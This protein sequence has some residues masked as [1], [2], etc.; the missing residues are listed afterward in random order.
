MN[1][2]PGLYQYKPILLYHVD[3]YY[4]NTAI[5]QGIVT[6]TGENSEFGEVFKLMKA[7]EVSTFINITNP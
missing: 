1:F 6:G 7:E 5:F 3:I 2:I 4:I